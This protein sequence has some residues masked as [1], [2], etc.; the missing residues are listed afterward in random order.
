MGIGS[1]IG[2]IAGGIGGNQINTGIETWQKYEDREFAAEEA[3]KQRDWQERM[4][5][6]AYQRAFEDM[7][8]AGINPAMAFS[9][10]A[11]AASPSG[12]SA[13]AT[14][15]KVTNGNPIAEGL[16]AAANF[17]NAF[18]QDR[19]RNNDINIAQVDNFM[20]N[21]YSKKQINSFFSDLDNIEV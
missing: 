4:S 20:K 7:E 12:A 6:T 13:N 15:G 10:N 3:Q 5:N 14:S 8:K 21:H 17:V 19:N 18:N 16:N 2:A 1:I 9:N 11:G